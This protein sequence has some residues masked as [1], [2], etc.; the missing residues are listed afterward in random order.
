MLKDNQHNSDLDLMLTEITDHLVWGHSKDAAVGFVQLA[1]FYGKAGMPV[2]TFY[3]MRQHI[4][5]TAIFKTGD[6]NY[7]LHNLKVAEQQLWKERRIDN[8]ITH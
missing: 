8:I 6:Q 4:V 3:D 2:Q 7:I 5:C 1:K